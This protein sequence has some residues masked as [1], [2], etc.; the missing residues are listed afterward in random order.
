MLEPGA[1]VIVRRTD[2]KVTR[3]YVGLKSIPM[4]DDG[5]L[6][7]VALALAKLREDCLK[8]IHRTMRSFRNSYD[9]SYRYDWPWTKPDWK[10][11]DL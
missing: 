7:P 4:D 1:G 5:K 10:R 11:P 2:G 8:D 6:D 9:W 3:V